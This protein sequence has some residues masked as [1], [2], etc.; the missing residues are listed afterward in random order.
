MPLTA[1]EF[2]FL[3]PALAEYTEVS[4]GL[5][6][7]V[8]NERKIHYSSLIW[9]MEARKCQ[10]PPRLIAGVAP[11]GTPTETLEFARRNETIPECP[12]P[13]NESASRR[14]KEIEPEVQAFREAQRKERTP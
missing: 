5:A 1:K 4:T 13:D 3:G 2:A 9:L 10:E 14:N 11:D 8:L 6:W 7:N 12:W